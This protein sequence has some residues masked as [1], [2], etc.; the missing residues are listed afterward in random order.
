M[1]DFQ[2]S[3]S[4]AAGRSRCRPGLRQG[5]AMAYWSGSI[6]LGLEW[7]EE[8]DSLCP[9]MLAVWTREAAG[10]SITQLGA[11]AWSRVLRQPGDPSRESHRDAEAAGLPGRAALS[12][13]VRQ[14]SPKAPWSR[15]QAYSGRQPHRLWEA[16]A[17]HQGGEPPRSQAQKLSCPG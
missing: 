4:A 13:A 14:L 15:R 17:E 3:M 6:Q 2:S 5:W 7:T 1:Q 9:R 16:P 11:P 10:S 8:L 12:A